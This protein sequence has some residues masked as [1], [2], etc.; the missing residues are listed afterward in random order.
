ML[1]I[2]QRFPSKERAERKGESGG[3]E[4]DF[5]SSSDSTT[6]TLSLHTAKRVP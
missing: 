1:T 6:H 2:Y 4:E 5:T 3:D